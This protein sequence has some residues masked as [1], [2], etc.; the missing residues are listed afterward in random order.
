MTNNDAWLNA[1]SKVQMNSIFDFMFF[2][3]FGVPHVRPIERTACDKTFGINNMHKY[4]KPFFRNK[5]LS[6]GQ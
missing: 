1:F 5:H 3:L 6:Y 4:I 2:V